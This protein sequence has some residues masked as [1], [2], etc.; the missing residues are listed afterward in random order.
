MC[1]EYDLGS[2][3]QQ[4]EMRKLP[5]GWV[6]ASRGIDPTEGLEKQE[7]LEGLEPG[8]YK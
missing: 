5:G 2:A 4:R 1:N 6:V 7:H 8:S 3:G